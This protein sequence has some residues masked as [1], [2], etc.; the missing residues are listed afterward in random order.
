MST[1]ACTRHD[2]VHMTSRTLNVQTLRAAV[3]ANS[4]QLCIHMTGLCIDLDS[5]VKRGDGVPG[6]R[7]GGG[8]ERWT[9]RTP[10]VRTRRIVN[11]MFNEFCETTGLH[12]WK[13]LTRV[14]EAF[15]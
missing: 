3:R 2:D 10:E 11:M 6:G 4:A 9:H 7:V 1:R 12:G 5:S 8:G 14:S 13:Y 15:Y